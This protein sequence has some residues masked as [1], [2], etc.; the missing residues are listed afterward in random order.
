MDN[1]TSALQSKMLRFAEL[2]GMQAYSAFSD[3][4]FVAIPWTNSR[5]NQTGVDM[6][7]CDTFAELR[8]TLGY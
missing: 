6:V 2:H 3:S 5:M 4:V 8:E 1:N 7:K